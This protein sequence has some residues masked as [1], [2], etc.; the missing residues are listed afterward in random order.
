MKLSV[1]GLGKLGLPLSVALA[2][3]GHEVIGV[4]I[5]PSVIEKLNQ[6]IPHLE[7]PQVEVLLKE[8]VEN[9]KFTATDNFEEAIQ[10]TEMSF[11]CVNTPD[12][13]DF[14]MDLSQLS[15]SCEMLGS[16]LKNKNDFHTFVINST[17]VPETADQVA[18]PTLEKFS[19][20]KLGEGFGLCVNPV[21]I[22]LSTVVKDLLHPPVVTLGS[23]D[24]KTAS[25]MEAFYK[26]FNE[27]GAKVIQTTPIMAEI[28]KLA[29][30]AYCTSKMAFI[31]E[32]SALCSNTPGADVSAMSEFFRAGGERTGRFLEAGMGFGGPCFPRDLKFFI[33]YIQDKVSASPL[34]EAIDTSN[35]GYAVRIVEL[36]EQELGSLKNKTV[37]VL[38]LAYKVNADITERSFSL[39]LIEVLHEK[40]A[41]IKSFDPRVK[42]VPEIHCQ[43]PFEINNSVEGSLK[44][45][46]FCIIAT[47]W[48]DFKDLNPEIFKQHM[49][50]ANLFD[51][52]RLFNTPEA[53]QHFNQYVGLGVKQELSLASI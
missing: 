41:T 11:I 48:Q 17:I 12:K 45:A 33:K 7:E 5:S 20:K 1:I 27:N 36:I 25:F 40:G 21:F 39:R 38:G 2:Q 8:A 10:N 3:K 23:S 16:A 30:N 9:K 37:S 43:T 50:E 15:S 22:A 34:I 31:N 49:S 53:K 29:H 28:I 26:S 51:P 13:N 52:W 19:D 4:D 14:E 42:Q 47:A 35:S 44:D 32:I 46:S 18:I 6:G 24:K